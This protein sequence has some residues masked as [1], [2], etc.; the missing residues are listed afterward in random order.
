MCDHRHCECGRNE[1]IRPYDWAAGQQGRHS[2]NETEPS[3]CV[4]LEFQQCSDHGKDWALGCFKC[5]TLVEDLRK[6]YEQSNKN[7]V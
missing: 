1:N 7:M 4:N 3:K 2:I 5:Q 6:K